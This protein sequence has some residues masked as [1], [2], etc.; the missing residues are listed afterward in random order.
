[1]LSGGKQWKGDLH[2]CPKSIEIFVGTS[3]AAPRRA[4]KVTLR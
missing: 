1:M 4:E 2:L 3:T